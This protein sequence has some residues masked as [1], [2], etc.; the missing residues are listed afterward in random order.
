[1]TVRAALA[2]EAH[3]FLSIA[4]LVVRRAPRKV[5]TAVRFSSDAPR[6]VRLMVGHVFGKDETVGQ[7]HHDAPVC[8]A[9]LTAE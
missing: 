1:M 3:K 5:E 9:S 7:Y 6:I 4:R 2:R 8:A